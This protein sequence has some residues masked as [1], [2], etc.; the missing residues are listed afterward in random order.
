MK[1]KHYYMRRFALLITVTVVFNIMPYIVPAAKGILEDICIF[2]L[3]YSQ[4][5]RHET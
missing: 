3:D 4:Y 2:T 1:K 5:S